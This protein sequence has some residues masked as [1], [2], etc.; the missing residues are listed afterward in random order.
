MLKCILYLLISEKEKEL[1]NVLYVI[2]VSY[3]FGLSA[4]ILLKTGRGLG[5]IGSLKVVLCHI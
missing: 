2:F 5:K 4:F 3:I 1:C